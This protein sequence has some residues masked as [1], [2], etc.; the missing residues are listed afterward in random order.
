MTPHASPTTQPAGAPGV[1][2]FRSCDPRTGVPGRERPDA[3]A[4]DLDAAL[5]TAAAA[6]AAWR[7]TSIAE[8]A[9]LLR[10]LADVL[11]GQAAALALTMAEEMG[12]PVT[13]G[14]AEARKCAWACRHAADHA[15]VW[16]ADEGVSTEARQSFVAHEPLGVVLAIM[17]WNFPLWQLFRFGASALAAGNVIVLK[18]APNVPRCAEAIV[19]VFAAAGAPPGLLV[20][21]FARVDQVEGLIADPRVAGVTLTG[22]T[23]AGRAVAAVAGQHLKPSVLELGGSDPFVVLR[24]AD[25]ARAAA[26]AAAARLQNNGQSCIAAKRFIVEAPV[27]EAFL[28]QLRAHLAAAV[29][30][31]PTDPAT[32]LGPLARRDLRDALHAQV[33]ASVDGGARVLLGGD[34]PARDGFWYP[35]TLLA[36]VGPGMPVWDDETFG[37]VAAVRVVADVDDAIRA[38]SA[39]PY[40]LGASVW[41]ADR[42]AGLRVARALRGGA[43][44][45]NAMV[46][47]DPRLPFGGNAASGFGRELGR[48]G[49]L[50]F[51]ASR[52]FWVE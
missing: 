49:M 44:F 35:A 12:K 20:N 18:H 5:D 4:A 41:T 15:D 42:D 14:M 40:A 39:T 34:V 8:R 51:T 43:A 11:E 1:A 31:D 45:V 37:P 7:A 27:A 6:S 22:S 47:S 50:A 19:A 26:T 13:Q 33:T 28:D 48:E 3:T 38:A 30:G 10:R 23:R 52:S 25:V 36:D 2:A 17:P 16:L 32:T 29:V 9:A 21:V 46:K 24:D